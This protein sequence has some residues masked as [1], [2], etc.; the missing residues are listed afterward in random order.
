M[1][2]SSSSLKTWIDERPFEVIIN[3]VSLPPRTQIDNDFG[4]LLPASKYDYVADMIY[5]DPII[6]RSDNTIYDTTVWILETKVPMLEKEIKKITKELETVGAS[7]D[8]EKS[9]KKVAELKETLHELILKERE[10]TIEKRRVTEHL[11]YYKGVQEIYQKEFV[12]L[13]RIA[14]IYKNTGDKEFVRKGAHWACTIRHSL[15]S[16]LKVPEGVKPIN[17]V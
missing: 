1:S 17:N 16:K 5:R 13:N 3:D 12:T 15:I 7:I 8:A 6:F 14:K 9:S 11:A 4:C 2:S 10:L